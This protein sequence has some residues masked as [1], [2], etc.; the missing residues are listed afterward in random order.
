MP[1][2]EH[3]AQFYASDGELVDS[4]VPFLAQG[5]AAD[6]KV[7]VVASAEHRQ[8]FEAELESLDINLVTARAA[9]MYTALDAAQTLECLRPRGQLLKDAFDEVIGA[10]VRQGGPQQRPVRAYSELVAL[11][12]GEGDTSSAIELERMWKGLLESDPLTLFC[13]YPTP[14]SPVQLQALSHICRSHSVVVPSI[15]MEEPQPDAA[16]V[17]TEFS[18]DLEAPGRARSLLR[19]ILRER[20]CSED[21]IER[22]VLA[23]SELAANA[24]LHARTPFRLLV[25]PLSSSLWIGVEDQ[26]PLRNRNEVVGRSPHGLGLIAAMALR[27]GVTPRS[28]GK[29]LWAE[30]PL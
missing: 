20:R 22:G 3:V 21:L 12:W 5:L 24:V 14:S 28:T 30:L 9:R 8:A 4:V 6:E 17:V 10:M 27:W 18:P 25:Q 2:C 11:L 7:V 23:V 19:A 29:L 16:T 13:A 1:V 15:T 26:A